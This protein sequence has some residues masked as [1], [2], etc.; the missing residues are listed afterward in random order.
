MNQLARRRFLKIAVGTIAAAGAGLGMGGGGA[1]GKVE[2]GQAPAATQ[3]LRSIPTFCDICF[4]KCGAIAQVQDGHC[5]TTWNYFTKDSR[6][7]PSGLLGPVT[8]LSE[9]PAKPLN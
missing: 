8:I 3:G 1:A 2:P 9:G 4:W 7:V 6:L 5:F